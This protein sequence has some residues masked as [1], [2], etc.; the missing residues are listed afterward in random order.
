MESSGQLSDL[1]CRV[2]FGFESLCQAGIM[3]Q[4]TLRTWIL[5]RP[6]IEESL[7]LAPRRQA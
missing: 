2:F 3:P 6:R 7:F 5:R 1:F 4:E